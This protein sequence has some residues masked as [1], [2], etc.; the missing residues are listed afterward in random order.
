MAS[1]NSSERDDTHSL[2]MF[3]LPLLA[4]AGVGLVM[5]YAVFLLAGIGSGYYVAEWALM[6][7][8]LVFCARAVLA[9]Y[10]RWVRL[11][12]FLF[13]AAAIPGALIAAGVY[14]RSLPITLH[15]FVLFGLCMLGWKLL[16]PVV[17]QCTGHTGR[18]PVR[19]KKI[20]FAPTFPFI[21]IYETTDPGGLAFS[22]DALVALVVFGTLIFATGDYLRLSQG[23][24][25]ILS[26]MPFALAFYAI[27]GGLIS[28]SKLV[29]RVRETPGSVRLEGGF[30]RTWASAMLTV[31]AICALLAYFL[32]KSPVIGTGSWMAGGIND[33]AQQYRNRFNLPESKTTYDF[34]R[35]PR[36]KA[37]FGGRGPAD[38]PGVGKVPG[39]AKRAVGP[40][41]R[42]T[43]NPKETALDLLY[44]AATSFESNP[45]EQLAGS[46][47]GGQSGGDAGKN[48]AGGNTPGKG[49]Q[50]KKNGSSGI[51]GNS[52]QSDQSDRSD[53]SDKNQNASSPQQPPQNGQ[54]ND[55]SDQLKQA[56]KNRPD[57][58]LKLLLILLL[59]LLI[60][61]ALALL[62]FRVIRR[63]IWYQLA[64]LARQ[65]WGWAGERLNRVLAPY[66]ERARQARHERRVLHLMAGIQPFTDPFANTEGKS[67]DD[68]ARAA[69]AAFLAHL[70]LLGYERRE[71]ETDFDFA[72]RLR[73][74]AKFDERAVMEITMGC[75]RSE[76]SST[77]LTDAELAQVQ[78]AYGQIIDA[79][80]ARIPEDARPEKMDAY[81][82]LLAERQL[83][84]EDARQRAPANELS[85]ESAA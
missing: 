59:A 19:R 43:N 13:F 4:V 48:N 6:L 22:G 60:A 81:R 3:Y 20:V 35:N 2:T 30:I 50:S 55:K 66:R 83:A 65:L 31:L 7:L 82:R 56:L 26:P 9:D 34:S 44:K 53:Q 72:A 64:N 1:L 84:R 10:S 37:P 27:A 32:P 67:N 77:P 58:L 17:E 28:L 41:S 18:E 15:A 57:R 45:Q 79:V 80:G 29:Q 68:I 46:R 61:L 85:P 33:R 54:S 51:S 12:F 8:L 36:G 74:Q 21:D 69:Y 52:N 14:L 49:S 42:P 63:Y 62:L 40:D 25:G 11:G 73:D 39:S 75:V 70:W 38:A 5:L 71:S 78:R 47:Q 76:F 24:A 23:Y 16:E